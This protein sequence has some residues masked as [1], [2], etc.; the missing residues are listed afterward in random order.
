[1]PADLRLPINPNHLNAQT[2]QL[3]SN[4]IAFMAELYVGLS[5]YSY[6]PWQGEDRFYPP[7]LKQKQFFNFYQKHYPAVEMDGTWY[8]MPGEKA[9]EGWDLQAEPSFRYTFKAH[10]N[11]THLGRLKVESIDSL[12]FMRKR[13]EPL[14][15]KGLLGA[16]FF[17]LPPNFKRNDQRLREFCESLPQP[18]PY[19]ME[20]RNESWFVPEVESILAE[21]NVA[22]ASWD[23]EDV[24]GQQRNSGNIIYSRMRRE[25]YTDEQL[26]H[27]AKWFER[28]LAAGKDCYVFFKHEDEGSPWIDADRLLRM[29]GKA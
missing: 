14:E 23:T 25:T 27:W 3:N 9:V 18:F 15:K 2:T 6:K 4:R 12:K 11:I 5:G 19:A 24:P 8:R 17:Q 29:M 7:D 10:R 22:W 21:H 13:L 26:G 1:M 20:F 16:I 28:A